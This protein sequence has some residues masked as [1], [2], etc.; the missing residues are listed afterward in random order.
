MKYFGIWIAV[1]F[2]AG[3]SGKI[4][5]GED[6]GT[7]AGGGDP[8]AEDGDGDGG[9]ENGNGD[10]GVPSGD[11]AVVGGDDG[12]QVID[13]GPALERC[14]KLP[15]ASGNFTRVTPG[16]NLAQ[17]VL[18]APEDHV[19]VLADGTYDLSSGDQLNFRRDGVTLRSESGDPG[20]V[21]ID[22]GYVS[23]EL[24]AI[25]ASD[26]TI[27]EV[28]L[29]RAYYHPI[30]V[31]GRSDAGIS[32]TRIYRVRIID[33]GEQAIKVNSSS[34]GYYT[35]YGKIE[36]CHIEL[37]GAGRPHIRNNCY[38]GGVDAHES[39]G[40]EIRDN[41]IK[42]FW[43][44]TGLS[45]HGVHM[46]Q[47]CRGT[48][49]ERNTIVD[50]ARGIGF[51]LGESG[52]GRDY[53]DDPYPGVGYIGHYDG[54]IRNNFVFAAIR[55][56]DSGIGLEQARGSQVVHNTVVSLQTPASSCI[57]WR[58]SNTDVSI[59]NN[60]VSHNLLDR[61]A[62]AE[63]AGNVENAPA[64]V[65]RDRNGGELHLTP[66]AASCI[67]QGVSLPAGLCDQDIDGEARDANPD[68][69]ADEYR[70]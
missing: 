5:W 16:Q 61:G 40:W 56:F 39:W 23:G 31:T 48:L 42:G 3:C 69:G 18:D 10:D 35:D 49:V 7:D 32:G 64:S 45:E 66:G 34:Q 28:T 15:A 2:L 47:G 30:H 52:T 62:Q 12:G 25:S 11:D 41:F 13:E 22:G 9:D 58:W 57:E 27:A 33:P 55:G 68:V 54:I 26:I 20:N 6:C 36:C 37:T 24:L 53:P 59:K 14:P 4:G 51:G 60:L 46:W 19:I 65:F 29:T 70:E 67:D 44:D 63:L 50:C 8:G 17:I 43:C 21:I 1:I 38:T